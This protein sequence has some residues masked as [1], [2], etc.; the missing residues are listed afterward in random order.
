[1]LYQNYLN[2]KIH[3]L[4]TQDAVLCFDGIDVSI[5][6]CGSGWELATE[7]PADHE[8]FV[9]KRFIKNTESYL[10]FKKEIE[11]ILLD[12]DFYKHAYS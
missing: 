9:I 10:A 4:H 2:T 7:V 11:G 12:R 8:S 1:M 3:L 5:K 6:L